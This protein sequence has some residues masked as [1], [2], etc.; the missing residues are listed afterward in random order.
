M[1]VRWARIVQKSL[2]PHFRNFPTSMPTSCSH[3]LALWRW[4]NM[5]DLNVTLKL[6]TIILTLLFV[7][8]KGLT[9]PAWK[10]CKCLKAN[11]WSLDVVRC[12]VVHTGLL[13]QTMTSCSGYQRPPFSFISCSSSFSVTPDFVDN[14]KLNR[15]IKKKKWKGKEG[16]ERRTS[17]QKIYSQRLLTRLS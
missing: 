16:K 1:L 8:R 12:R 3:W 9:L 4:E 17:N 7:Y 10:Q 11:F 5:Q 13:K 15:W 14:D 6:S 2:T